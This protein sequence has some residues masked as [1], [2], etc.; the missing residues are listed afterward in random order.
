MQQICIPPT[1]VDRAIARAGARYTAPCIQKPARL[2]TWAGDKHV[3]IGL[4][5]AHWL[6]S[7]RKGF[8]R[9]VQAD[10]LLVTLAAASVVPTVL[11]SIVDQE[12][13]DRCMVGPERR[14][15]ETSGNARD[16]FPSGHAVNMGALASALSWIY[17]DKKLVFWGLAAAVVSTRVA[18][19]AHWTSD[20]V[21]GGVLGIGLEAATRRVAIR[22]SCGSRGGR[23]DD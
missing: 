11:K 5:A 21:L 22:R 8:H 2:A 23:L 16:A 9:R 14:G 20:V 4:A 17:P 15:I 7:R 6:I 18:I 10:H 13:P 19:L 3:L 12:R 1:S